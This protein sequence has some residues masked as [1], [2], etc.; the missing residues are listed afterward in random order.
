MVQWG[1]TQVRK[2]GGKVFATGGR[3][4]EEPR[5]TIKGSDIAIEMRKD[6]TAAVQGSITVRPA[7]ANAL[8]S[9]DA[10]AKPCAA[11][12]AAI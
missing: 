3:K 1:G 11:V 8:V 6:Q 9:R 2:F 12:I 7:A 5:F 10:T 4:N